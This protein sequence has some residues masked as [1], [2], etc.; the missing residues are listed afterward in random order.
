MLKARA[1]L[2]AKLIL[3]RYT[4]TPMDFWLGAKRIRL[5][6]GMQNDSASDEDDG[7]SNTPDSMLF[8]DLQDPNQH[9]RCVVGIN[10]YDDPTERNILQWQEVQLTRCITENTI[11]HVVETY[12][13]M[14]TDDNIR[15]QQSTIQMAI[16]MAINE[17]GLQQTEESN[18]TTPPARQDYSR[19]LVDSSDDRRPIESYSSN[20]SSSS[21]PVEV[22]PTSSII[23]LKPPME[24]TSA[25][26]KTL[27]V[28]FSPPEFNDDDELD[29]VEDFEYDDFSDTVSEP[30]HSNF[31]EAAVAAAIQKKGL[32]SSHSSSATG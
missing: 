28:A 19:P 11:N 27:A 5:A 2:I 6:D 14:F 13:N 15:L 20:S 29:A 4:R 7:R 24:S 9:S 18:A 25:I 8:R 30:D 22:E 1:F 3:F 16:R 10:D 21:N 31:L 17:H 23:D 32:S 12:I 26:P